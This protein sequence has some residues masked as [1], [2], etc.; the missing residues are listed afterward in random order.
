[1]SSI[2]AIIPARGG[3]KGIPGK[4]VMPI[5]GKPLIAWT[6]GAVGSATTSI[7]C[8]VSTDD[9]EIALIALQYGAEVIRRPTVLATDEAPTE[10]SLLHVLDIVSGEG[11]DP[12][13]VMLLQATSPV[14]RPGTIDAALS[15]IK[16]EGSTSLVA[17][18]E[19]HPFLWAGPT[20]KPKPLYD[21]DARPRRQDLTDEQRRY[22]ETGS[23][24]VTTPTALRTSGNRISGAVSLFVLTAEESGDIDTVEDIS[25]AE[26]LLNGVTNVAGS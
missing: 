11:Y 15:Q 10:P 13:Y 26:N 6:I 3:S 2:L 20:G 5:A 17:V 18:V 21:V 23:L 1:M 7:R 25:V 24:Y 16:Q 8:V 22:R 19:E 4:N 9:E 14:R 12:E